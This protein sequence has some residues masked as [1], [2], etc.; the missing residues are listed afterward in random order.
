MLKVKKTIYGSLP[1]NNELAKLT[2]EIEQ[3][4]QKIE[5]KNKQKNNN[6]KQQQNN[7]WLCKISTIDKK[8]IPEVSIRKWNIKNK[9][10]KTRREAAHY[11][12]NKSPQ[13]TARI[14]W[15][16]KKKKAL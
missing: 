5:E 7:Q 3:A 15:R 1:K 4:I 8:R 6:K 10:K 2:T 12:I 13:K 9:G 16:R 11:W 14:F